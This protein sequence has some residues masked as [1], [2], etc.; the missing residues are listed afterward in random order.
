LAKYATYTLAKENIEAFF[1]TSADSK[2][3]QGLN[4]K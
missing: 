2:T 1:D 4:F 3:K